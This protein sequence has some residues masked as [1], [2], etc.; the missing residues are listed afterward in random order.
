MLKAL[1][2]AVIASTA[3]FTEAL[4]LKGNL[5]QG[6]MVIGKLPQASNIKL[7]ERAIKRSKEGYFVFGFGRDAELSHT[8][9]WQSQDGKKHSQPLLITKRDYDI[10]KITGVAKKY[11]S[12]PE[13]VLKRIREEAQAVSKARQGDSDLLYFKE[14]VYRP[15]KGRIS[16]IYGSQR[17]FNGEPRRPHFGLDIANKTGEPVYAPVS[18]VVVFANSD[19]YYSGGTLIIDHGHGITST[20]IHLS[21]LDVKAGD[22]VTTGDKIA[23][24]GATGRVTGPHLDWR[25]NWFGERLDPALLM[26]ETLANKAVKK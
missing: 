16:G 18:G 21:K 13:S 23:E 10:D 4:E 6:G 1:M 11:V 17:Y 26:K 24:I 19:L 8:L 20:Y 7:N 3:L 25:F 15:A 5:T 9:S 12:P 14:T 2:F 22:K